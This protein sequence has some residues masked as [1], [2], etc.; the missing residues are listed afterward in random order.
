MNKEQ[1]N[2]GTRGF[3]MSYFNKMILRG[4]TQ[5]LKEKEEHNIVILDPESELQPPS[6]K[7][8]S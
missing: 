2:N 7:L 5:V 1:Q 4:M 3:G 8:H 6:K